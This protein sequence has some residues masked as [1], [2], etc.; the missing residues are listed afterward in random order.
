MSTVSPFLYKSL[1]T[2]NSVAT[3]T[4]Q[5]KYKHKQ[6]TIQNTTIKS[7]TV[8]DSWYWSINKMEHGEN[9]WFCY[10]RRSPV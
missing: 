2:E 10:R 3:K 1:F 8:V 9:K 7:I 6:D 5:R 4:Q